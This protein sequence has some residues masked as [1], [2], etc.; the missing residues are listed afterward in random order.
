[1]R[2]PRCLQVV[3]VVVVV[4]SAPSRG[5]WPGLASCAAFTRAIYC[6]TRVEAAYEAIFS[7]WG[8]WRAALS[9]YSGKP[10]QPHLCILPRV[11]T[12]MLGK[13]FVQVYSRLNN[14]Y[15]LIRWE[16]SFTKKSILTVVCLRH[17]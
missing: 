2:Q 1:M 4:D 9:M 12:W 13:I 10:R 6:V 7:L 15:F 11:L 14:I 5:I 8:N 16:N 3:V 17:V